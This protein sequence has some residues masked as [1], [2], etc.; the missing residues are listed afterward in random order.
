MK[1]LVHT[2]ESELEVVPLDQLG[3]LGWGDDHVKE[4]IATTDDLNAVDVRGMC[5]QLTD[6]NLVN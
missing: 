6:D 3:S 1:F 4:V 2:E 5:E